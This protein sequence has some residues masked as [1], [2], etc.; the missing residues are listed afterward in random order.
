MEKLFLDTNVVLDLIEKREPFVHDAA[1]LFQLRIDG[2][3]QLF[4]SDL[5]IVNIAYIVRKSYS[6][7]KLYA[8]L[9]KLY[10]FLVI[11]P[12]GTMV[13][14]RAIE[15]Q[16]NDFEDAV[17]YYAACQAKVDYMITRNKKDYSFSEIEVLTPQEY[18][19]LKHIV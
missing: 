1:L 12:G 7:E 4:V 13:I 3:C 9:D 14:G 19:F 17:Q 15:S 18:M 6:K 8:I 16:A 11:V 5:T 10:S 2:E